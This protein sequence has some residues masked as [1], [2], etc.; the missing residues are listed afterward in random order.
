MIVKSFQLYFIVNNFSLGHKHKV[1]C[2]RRGLHPSTAVLTP[3]RMI[4]SSSTPPSTAPSECSSTMPRSST[5]FKYNPLSTSHYDTGTS[6][7]NSYCQSNGTKSEGSREG[8]KAIKTSLLGDPP[9]LHPCFLKNDVEPPKLTKNSYS[10]DNKGDGLL[11]IPD[12]LKPFGLHASIAANPSSFL[13]DKAFF[14]GSNI[15]QQGIPFPFSA[16]IANQANKH[17]PLKK[18]TKPSR[19]N[20]NISRRYST[21]ESDDQ[22]GKVMSDLINL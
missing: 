15:M 18:G 22:T 8:K 7:N 5:S 9:I 17:K 21:T 1:R 11:P 4:T 20:T 14:V 2:F 6:S 19:N 12:N 16:N 13:M 3:T 10:N